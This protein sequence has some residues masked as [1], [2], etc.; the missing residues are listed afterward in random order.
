[1]SR[2]DWLRRRIAPI[3][4]FLAIALIAR[5]SCDKARRTHAN[6][7]LDFGDA[8]P[9]IHAVDVRVVAGSETVTT[10]QRT[11]L[12]PGGIGDCKFAAVLPDEDGELRID[13]DLGDAHRLLVR[14]FHAVEGA[15]VRV[16]IRDVDLR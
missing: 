1:V 6:V 14:R 16:P 8:R 12:G 11:A 3:A 10:Y 15:T 9:R 4:F 13:V 7:E 5:D 2:Y